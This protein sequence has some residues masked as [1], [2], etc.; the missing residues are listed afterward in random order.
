MTTP[1]YNVSGVLKAVSGQPYTPVIESGF[2]QGLD[3][4]SGRKP[5]AMVFDLRAERGVT[6]AGTR[7]GLFV[8]GLNLLDSRFFNGPV[9]ESTG[10]PYYSRFPEA[11][12]V[13]LT[14]PYRFLAPR[15]I[16]FGI[17]FGSQAPIPEDS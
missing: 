14:N 9:Y 3:T 17:R 11:D 12:A 6:L 16:E 8:R 5:S 13:A 10:S 15:R 1:T 7:A 4:N 2:G